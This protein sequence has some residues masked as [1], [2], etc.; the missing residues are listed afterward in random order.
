MH[1]RG[2]ALVQD[3]VVNRTGNLLRNGNWDHRD[4]AGGDR[5]RSGLV[6]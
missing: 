1:S 5:G 4:P 3:I 2:M 6:A